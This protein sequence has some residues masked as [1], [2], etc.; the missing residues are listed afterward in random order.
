M[1]RRRAAHNAT[2]NLLLVDESNLVHR[3]LHTKGELSDGNGNWT[4]GLYGFLTSVAKL[5][6][7]KRI[8]RMLVCR[9]SPPYLRNTVY[10]EYKQDR[11]RSTDDVYAKL[12]TARE[13]LQLLADRLGL[14]IGC[15]RGW[16]A[17]DVIATVCKRVAH[18]F[19]GVYIS[20]VDTDLYQCLTPGNVYLCKTDNDY[21]QREFSV[22]FN[23]HPHEWAA[24][25]A[26]CGGHNNLPG[27]TGVGIKTAVKIARENWSKA[28]FIE[29]YGVKQ[30][31]RLYIGMQCVPLPHPLCDEHDLRYDLHNPSV[32]YKSREFARWLYQRYAIKLTPKM[33][34]ALERLSRG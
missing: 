31:N 7:D 17:D 12:T 28:K 18:R 29:R 5:I 16:E 32:N 4:G 23:L 22:E 19:D 15:V 33:D 20:S 13:Q 26:L 30:Y 9:D 2:G 11:V 3:A 21:G 6:N 14:A 8:T 1:Q 25:Q 34:A 24:V 10:T 27:V